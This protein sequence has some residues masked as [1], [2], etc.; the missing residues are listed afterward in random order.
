MANLKTLKRRVQLTHQKRDEKPKPIP[1]ID[2]SVEKAVKESNV[3][4]TGALKVGFKSLEGLL[5]KLLNRPEQAQVSPEDIKQA[6]VDGMKSAKPQKITFPARE[7]VSYQATIQH[8]SRGK[9]TG[10]RIEPIAD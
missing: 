10:A 9:M 3:Q 6:V 2:R 5:K 7:P 4:I 8:N 1:R